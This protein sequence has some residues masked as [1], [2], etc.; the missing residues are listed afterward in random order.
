MAGANRDGEG[1][2][3]GINVTPLVDITLVL[4]IIFIVTAKIIVTPAVPLELPKAA[5]AEEVQI[6]LSVILERPGRT[7]ID[8]APVADDADF[9]AK[10]ADKAAQE[11]DVRAVISADGEVPHRRV[12]HTLDLLRQA[13][14]TKV[15]FAA[16]PLDRA[17]PA[18]ARGD[19]RRG[20]HPVPAS[21]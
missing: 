12:L 16:A 20:N 5:T 10:V 13:Q 9:L 19:E 8:G 18:P 2:I 7:L 6:V 3:S 21:P 11:R 17:G 15:A 4:L 1:L 14:I